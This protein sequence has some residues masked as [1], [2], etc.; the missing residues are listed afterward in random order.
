VDEQQPAQIL[1]AKSI[2]A[3]SSVTDRTKFAP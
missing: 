3:A 1:P 2:A